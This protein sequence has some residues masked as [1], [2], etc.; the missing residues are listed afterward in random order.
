VTVVGIPL[1]L[2][3]LAALPLVYAL[4]YSATG[5]ILGRSILRR[6]T[7]WVVAFLAGWAILRVIT[8]GGFSAAWSGA[9]QQRS[10][11]VRWPW[12]FGGP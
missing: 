9:P 1:A 10:A 4:G 8:L 7:A 2:G 6:P 3:L 5:W 11:W 12:P